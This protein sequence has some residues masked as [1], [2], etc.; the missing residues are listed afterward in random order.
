MT[1]LGA[2]ARGKAAVTGLWL[3]PGNLGISARK[4]QLSGAVSW[5][6]ALLASGRKEGMVVR[7]RCGTEVPF[8]LS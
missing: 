5:V 8:E 1:T 6:G 3:R 7:C 4:V 2:K